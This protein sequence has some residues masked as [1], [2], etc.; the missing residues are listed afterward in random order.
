MQRWL[1]LAALAVLAACG[2]GGGGSSAAP[3]TVTVTPAATPFAGP[4]PVSASTT[5]PNGT[6]AQALPSVAGYG[7]SVTAGITQ[8]SG[9]TI[10]ATV[11]LGPLPAVVGQPAPTAY[12]NAPGAVLVYA[13]FVVSNVSSVIASQP[14]L[15]FT[16]PPGTL[17]ANTPYYYAVWPGNAQTPNWV[18]GSTSGGRY[19]VNTIVPT[20]APVTITIVG[21]PSIQFASGFLWGFAV[22]R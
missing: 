11:S 4:S 10:T 6:L 5:I 1:A 12:T 2:G 16:F 9:G 21:A 7:G 22:Y 14:T 19:P 18:D 20:N 17:L 8:G 13:D 15:T 3:P